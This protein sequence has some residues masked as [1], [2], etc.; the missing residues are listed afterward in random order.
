VIGQG[1]GRRSKELQRQGATQARERK[2]KMEVDGHK[3]V[4]WL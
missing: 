4:W 3:P 2:T 1:K